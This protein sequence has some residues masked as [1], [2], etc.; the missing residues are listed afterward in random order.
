VVFRSLLFVCLL[1]A[2]ACSAEVGD[3]V[4]R[5]T[6]GPG[7]VS[8]GAHGQGRVLL[9]R[10]RTMGNTDVYASQRVTAR[11]LRATPG[12]DPSVIARLVSSSEERQ[13]EV[14]RGCHERQLLPPHAPSLLHE[15]QQDA[16]RLR[17][18]GD[19]AIELLDVG[20][21]GLVSGDE[22]HP[23]SPRAF[24]TVAALVSGMVY[25]SRD[26]SWRFPQSEPFAFVATGSADTPAFRFLVDAPSA[27]A[28][29]RLGDLDPSRDEIALVR[30]RR[31]SLSWRADVAGDR[32]TVR[33]ESSADQA[34]YVLCAFADHGT[35]VI[36]GYF[37]QHQAGHELNVMVTRQRRQQH[38]ASVFE[39]IV[40]D[41]DDA[42]RV[43]VTL[44][45]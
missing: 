44:V 39:R 16:E 8:S 7:N 26:D 14:E 6:W 15:L 36:P 38:V 31:L 3:E 19:L 29:L 9:E 12:A 10:Q 32:V 41:F 37:F 25:T 45:D 33:F 18:V 4:D 42:V 40:V 28:E 34:S 30:G 11:F 27:L 2:T 43:R 24:P 35:A 22:R 13:R 1:T 20:D 23:L 17:T 21:V 5:A